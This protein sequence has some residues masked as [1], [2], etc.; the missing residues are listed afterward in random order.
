MKIK[1]I[2]FKSIGNISIRK[3]REVKGMIIA[4]GLLASGMIVGAGLLRGEHANIEIFKALFDEFIIMR[5]EEPAFRIFLNSFI[6][7]TVC[8]I[9]ATFAGMSCFG[10]PVAVAIPIIKGFG[11][12]L[13]SGYLFREF[14]MSGIGYYLLTV[15]PG[16]IFSNSAL[17]LICNNACFMSA[18]ILAVSLAK[19]QADENMIKEYLKKIIVILL[20]VMI[21]SVTDC[22]LVKAFAYLFTF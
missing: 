13:L 20:M 10:M 1:T 2:K 18:D 6:L 14:S 19:K 12:G 5:N 21:S 16:G 7:N 3:E 9:I 22:L 8:V 11:Y 4:I 15:L 17:L